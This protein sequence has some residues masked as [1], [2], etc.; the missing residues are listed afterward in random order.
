VLELFGLVLSTW[1]FGS[2]GGTAYAV[3]HGFSNLQTIVL[4]ALINIVLVVIWFGIIG[5]VAKRFRNFVERYR[6]KGIEM[7]FLTPRKKARNLK[8][9]GLSLV[10]AFTIG[11]LW[12]VIGAYA[13]NA[14]KWVAWAVITPSAVM[15]GLLWTLGSLGIISF[16]PSPWWL[17]L[18]AVG[19]TIALVGRKVYQNLDQIRGAIRQIRGLKSDKK[20]E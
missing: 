6:E 12:A 9:M 13:I 1:A 20:K 4:I 5:F 2:V 15:A 8:T 7:P 3:A 19:V 10:A 17:Y 11:S 16:L 14:N 18:V